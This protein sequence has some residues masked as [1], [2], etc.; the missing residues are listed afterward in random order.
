LYQQLEF[1][2]VLCWRLMPRF[3]VILMC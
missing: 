1:W 3:L 2:G